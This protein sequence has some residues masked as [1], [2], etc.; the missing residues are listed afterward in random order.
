MEKQKLKSYKEKQFIIFKFE[1]GKKVKYNLAT[2]E[3][4]GKS[5]RVVKDIKTQLSGYNLLEIINSFEDENYKD[6]LLFVD[7]RVNKSTKYWSSKRVDKIRNIGTFLQHIE[8]YSHIEQFFACGI[9]N[10]SPC[11]TTPF[12]K[13]SKGLLKIIRD[14]GYKVDD[15]LIESYNSNPDLFLKIYNLL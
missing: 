11:L 5:G 8:P 14:S 1:D 4:I 9:K 6:F 12:S 7:G 2:N 15:D 13:V 3:S 10:I